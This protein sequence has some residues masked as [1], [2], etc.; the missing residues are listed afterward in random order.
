MENHNHINL[1]VCTKKYPK[2]N[3]NA[4][5]SKLAS[6]VREIQN[7]NQLNLLLTNEN[8]H[9]ESQKLKTYEMQNPNTFQQT[10]NLDL[11]KINS[12]RVLNKKS[13]KSFN[14]TTK[15]NPDILR[16]IN[17][18]QP[19]HLQKEKVNYELTKKY[20]TAPNTIVPQ[21]QK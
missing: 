2:N 9:K 21:Q 4:Y 15:L 19:I 3:E 17:H 16:R 13:H 12:M 14:V 5:V 7:K 20:K 18:Q 10:K 11:K 8:F 1:P 6:V